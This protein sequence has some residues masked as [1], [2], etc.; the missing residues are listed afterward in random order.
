MKKVVGM[1]KNYKKGGIVLMGLSLF[2][3]FGFSCGTGSEQPTETDAGTEEVGSIIS[4]PGYGD[5]QALRLFPEFDEF[6]VE[7]A[8]TPPPE[9]E[10]TA[11]KEGRPQPVAHA[12]WKEFTEGK[13]GELRLTRKRL[14]DFDK[15]VSLQMESKGIKIDDTLQTVTIDKELLLINTFSTWEI[16]LKVEGVGERFYF[17]NTRTA[18]NEATYYVERDEDGNPVRGNF[19]WLEPRGKNGAYM[20]V[21]LVYDFADS[22]PLM[23]MRIDKPHLVLGYNSVY[24]VHYVCDEER[25][26]CQGEYYGIEEP[27]PKRMISRA[28]RLSWNNSTWQVCLARISYKGGAVQVL[29][30]YQFKGP[31][32]PMVEDVQGP[33]IPETP[34]WD[35][36]VQPSE[37]YVRYDDDPALSTYTLYLG[38]G[39]TTSWES[40]ILPEQIDTWPLGQ[41]LSP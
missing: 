5:P 23:L 19:A 11:E 37:L 27:P 20:V 22:Q 40:L 2:W 16:T 3:L 10:N 34:P 6:I 29:D 18:N 17:K 25:V 41:G 33:C 14:E 30:S 24:H 35:H 15:E 36:A 28:Y 32:A 8:I 39:S 9:E 12:T 4:N 38:D 26:A 7:A 13:L 1:K 31:F 21:G